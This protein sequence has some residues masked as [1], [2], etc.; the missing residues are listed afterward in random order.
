MPSVGS[1][2]R[3]AAA[4][5]LVGFAL[6]NG[7][8]IYLT[9]ADRWFWIAAAAVLMVTGAWGVLIADAERPTSVWVV[10]GAELITIAAM[11]PLLWLVTSAVHRG[12]GTAR[13]L[14]PTS[15]D[16]APFGDV[17]TGRSFGVSVMLA[18][19]VALVTV[20]LCLPLVW[21]LACAT[22]TRRARQRHL[23][24]PRSRR[25]VPTPVVVV[26]LVLAGP[27]VAL[28]VPWVAALRGVDDSRG[29]WWALPGLLILTVPVGLVVGWATLRGLRWDLFESM[30]VDGATRRQLL[31]HV[32][33]P[34]LRRPA[35]MIAA[36]GFVVGLQNA[37][38]GAVLVSSSD[39]QPFASRILLGVES[40]HDAAAYAL[41]VAVPS[42]LVVVTAARSLLS[43][44]SHR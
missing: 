28:L 15:A 41:M 4:S 17:V 25:S 20:A 27:S 35:A 12:A 3:A 38:V 7:A 8:S 29:L 18:L 11:V 44:R 39:D 40:S 9:G 14:V 21:S 24:V 23:L 30:V 10:L 13:S 16:L 19:A 33:V 5:F 6:A 31:A 2:L 22:A 26:V 43:G 34:A 32:V 1:R 36:A 37:S 42:L